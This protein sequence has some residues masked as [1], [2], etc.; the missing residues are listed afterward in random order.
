MTYTSALYFGMAFLNLYIIC[1]VCNCV[2]T[3]DMP[4]D[5]DSCEM[6]KIKNQMFKVESLRLPHLY[7]KVRM[8]NSSSQS[9]QLKLPAHPAPLQ[10]GVGSKLETRLGVGQFVNSARCASVL[11]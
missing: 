10:R 1:T 7:S 5:I 9:L 8:C 6:S 2:Y 11:V 4:I 3:F